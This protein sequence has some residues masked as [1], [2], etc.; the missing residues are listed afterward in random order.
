MTKRP[1]YRNT[2]LA[3]LTAN[4][5]ELVE[6]SYEALQS[7]RKTFEF[8]TVIGRGL[9]VLRAKA[10]RM[11]G[12]KTFDRLR[13][14]AG[15]GEKHLSRSHVSKLL[16]VMDALPDVEA[17]RAPLTEK[18]KFDWASPSAI[19][20]HCPHFAVPTDGKKPPKRHTPSLRDLDIARAR[21]VE[22][23]E[24]LA[25]MP[26]AKTNGKMVLFDPKLSADAI[27]EFILA[28][29][30]TKT[31]KAV[32]AELVRLTGKSWKGALE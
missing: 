17:W 12:R 16:R 19:L 23:E 8:W 13:E 28:N 27:V 3:D 22:L 2:D 1:D 10:D 21:I 7:L 20:K 24:E 15:L 25:A 6:A 18:Q 26:A 4:E 11:G 5:R 14:Q 32:A 31:A 30:P 9:M 29:V